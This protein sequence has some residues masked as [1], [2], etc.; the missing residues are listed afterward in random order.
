[1]FLKTKEWVE[2]YKKVTKKEPDIKDF[3]K[4]DDLER[5]KNS[6]IICQKH[7][8]FIKLRKKGIV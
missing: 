8:I 3:K 4:T 6:F 2:S 7:E 5:F 1:M